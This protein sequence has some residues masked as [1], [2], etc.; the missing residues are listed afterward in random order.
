MLCIQHY[1]KTVHLWLKHN[2][3]AIVRKTPKLTEGSHRDL[4][5]NRHICYYFYVFYFFLKSKK[6]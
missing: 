3:L 4:Q 2:G 6:S 1:I 5:D